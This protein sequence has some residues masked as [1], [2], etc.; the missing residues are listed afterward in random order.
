MSLSF[1]PQSRIAIPILW[2]YCEGQKNT[3]KILAHRMC[4]VNILL[5]LLFNMS[6]NEQKCI[7]HELKWTESN[8]LLPFASSSLCSS[9]F[10]GH[11]YQSGTH[12]QSPGWLLLQDTPDIA[13]PTSL[14]QKAALLMRP[15]LNKTS[16]FLIMSTHHW[17]CF[18]LSSPYYFTCSLIY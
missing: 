17:T 11:F 16:V 8:Y 10:L 5:L 12:L 14:D 4:L 2:V 13:P 15:I 7:Y 3:H 18:V 6:W 9:T 1:Y